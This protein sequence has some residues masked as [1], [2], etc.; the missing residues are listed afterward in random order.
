MSQISSGPPEPLLFDDEPAA[1]A[2]LVRPLQRF[3]ALEVS[4]GLLLALATVAALVWVNSPW[5]ETYDQVWHLTG[6]VSLGD[7]S[8]SLSLLHWIDDGLMALFFFVVG[9][10]IKRELLV[11]ELASL[12]QAALPV[13]AA[14]GGMV[15]PAALYLA[16]NAGGAGSRGWAC[17]LYTSPSPRD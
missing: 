2:R 7:R 13:A 10:E 15:L 1:V 12:R 3:I 14:L 9:L 11:G 8:L 17:L 5:R 4:G 6:R 16:F